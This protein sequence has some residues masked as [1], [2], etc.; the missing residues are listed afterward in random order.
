MGKHRLLISIECPKCNIP[1]E[2]GYISPLTGVCDNKEC[3]FRL[4]TKF[5]KK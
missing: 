2:S 4:G 5:W 1:N 3:G